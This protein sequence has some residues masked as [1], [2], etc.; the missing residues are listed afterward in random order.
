MVRKIDSFASFKVIEIF[1]DKAITSLNLLKKEIKGNE[2][3]LN[4]TYTYLCEAQGYLNIL[5][6][7]MSYLR[8]NIEKSK[9]DDKEVV[10]IMTSL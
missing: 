8:R 6:K 2:V 5:H 7:Q 3:D 1:I 10:N 4:L 9:R